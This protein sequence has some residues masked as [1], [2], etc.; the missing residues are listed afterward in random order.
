VDII[1][2]W[3]RKLAVL[4]HASQLQGNGAAAEAVR[5][6]P[7]FLQSVEATHIWFQAMRGVKFGEP[8]YSLGP[9][10]LRKSPLLSGQSSARGDFP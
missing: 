5:S 1:S 6:Q 3:P 10:G 2:V 4:V 7:D 9:V 8:V